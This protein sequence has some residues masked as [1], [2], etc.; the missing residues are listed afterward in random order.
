M[1][2]NPSHGTNVTTLVNVTDVPT[3]SPIIVACQNVICG[4]AATQDLWIE[5]VKLEYIYKIY[6][7][8][9]NVQFL[10]TL[11]LVLI[12]AV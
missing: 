8:H 6:N 5:Y 3:C 1:T 7:K 2:L 12:L 9:K 10:S 4:T 11:L